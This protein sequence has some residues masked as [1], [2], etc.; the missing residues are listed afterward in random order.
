MIWGVLLA[1]FVA[2]IALRTPLKVDIIRDRGAL[3]REVEGRWIENVYRLQLINTTEGPMH[4]SVRA[5]SDELKNLTVEY[6]KQ[7]ESLAPTSNRLLPIRI[8]VP[9]EDA[10]Q[11][12][13]K[14]SVT[15]TSE[16]TERGNAEIRQSTSFIV[17]RDL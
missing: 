17:P 4:I 9:L 14:I 6:D 11:G 8:R 13:H 2:S 3:G 15:V 12:T 5:D 10:A 1:G 16:G 7:A